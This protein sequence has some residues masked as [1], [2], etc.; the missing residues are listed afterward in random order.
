MSQELTKELVQ[1]LLGIKGEVRGV[2]FRTDREYV[3][4]KKGEEYLE[5]VE[6]ELEKLGYPIK[7]EEIKSMNFYPIGLRIL[8]LLVIKEVLNLN[9]DAI[10]EMGLVATKSSLIIK[11]LAKFFFSLQRVFATEAPKIWKKHYTIGEIEPVELNEE[12]KYAILRL[13]DFKVHKIMCT[14]LEG[15]FC[16]IGQLIIKTSKIESKET[17]CPFLGDEYHEF[18]LTWE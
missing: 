17:K 6:K 4:R 8:S 7:Y 13:K 15:Y 2:V 5:K 9:D 11:I 16:G 12:K 14:Y 18:L 1:K 10:K 3:L